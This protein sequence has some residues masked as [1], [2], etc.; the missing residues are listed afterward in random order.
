MTLS[1]GEGFRSD[2]V[3]A[4]VDHAVQQVLTLIDNPRNPQY[5]LNDNDF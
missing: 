3:T 4:L 2:A 1:K 5:K